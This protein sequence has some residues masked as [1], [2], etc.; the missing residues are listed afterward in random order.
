MTALS[1]QLLRDSWASPV[2][3][4]PFCTDSCNT[5]PATNRYSLLCRHLLKARVSFWPALF[6]GNAD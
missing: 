6:L 1:R 5:R 4:L 2:N 3:L